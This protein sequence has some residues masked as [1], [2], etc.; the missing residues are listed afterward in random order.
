MGVCK[1]VSYVCLTSSVY[2]DEIKTQL[3]FLLWLIPFAIFTWKSFV[4]P[5]LNAQRVILVLSPVVDGPVTSVLK[6]NLASGIKESDSSR[7]AVTHCVFRRNVLLSRWAVCIWEK[8][9]VQLFL[10]LPVLQKPWLLCLPG[11][12]HMRKWRQEKGQKVIAYCLAG[13]WYLCFLG[14]CFL[15]LNGI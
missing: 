7:W 5:L 12:K 6:F 4:L 3:F 13:D 10:Y 14:P 9:Y 11:S 8:L 15:V 1:G 2:V